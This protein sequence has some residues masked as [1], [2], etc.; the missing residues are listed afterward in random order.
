MAFAIGMC[1]A[2][3]D[4]QQRLACYDQIAARL[5][6]G[7]PIG[8]Q[9]SAPQTPPPFYTPTPAPTGAPAPAYIPPPAAAYTPP[10][11]PAYSP[12]PAPPT[13]AQA[14]AQSF[15]K[16]EATP[17]QRSHDSSWYDV[18]SWFGSSEEPPQATTGTPAEFGAES[19]PAPKAAAGEPAA[20]E[21]LD[22]ITAAV[23]GVAI[24]G[25]GKFTVT[26]DNGQMWKQIDGDTGIAQFSKRGGDRVTISRGFLGSYNLVV[27]G[28]TA[29]FKVKRI[30]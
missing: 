1:S 26:L 3:A 9:A 8:P 14:E 17:V 20:P 7:E 4:A 29:M 12:A 10:P 11:A 2:Q 25:N 27:A 21:P 28:K 15:G 13:P 23:T 16:A 5:K 18:G 24:S 22:H 19:L 6:A 30:Q